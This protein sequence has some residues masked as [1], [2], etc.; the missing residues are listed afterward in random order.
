MQR[1]LRR[2]GTRR[3]IGAALMALG[4][5][6]FVAGAAIDGGAD[7]IVRLLPD[8]LVRFA[9]YHPQKLLYFLG[10]VLF[11]LGTLLRSSAG[12]RISRLR[13]AS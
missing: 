7:V 13:A 9:A 11:G 10:P 4:V 8:A 5:V 1:A 2:A 12:R 6:T 3:R